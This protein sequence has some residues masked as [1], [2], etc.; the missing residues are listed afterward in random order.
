MA[1]GTTQGAHGGRRRNGLPRVHSPE[2][3]TAR[4]RLRSAHIPSTSD[5]YRG[6]FTPPGSMNPAKVGRG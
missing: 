3:V 5:K 2:G 1:N 6:G 4:A